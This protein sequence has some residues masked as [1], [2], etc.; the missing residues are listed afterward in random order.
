M[1]QAKK[2]MM[3]YEDNIII[4]ENLITLLS[5]DKLEGFINDK[6]IIGA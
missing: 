4:L 5:N 2:Q 6:I 1:G 3:E